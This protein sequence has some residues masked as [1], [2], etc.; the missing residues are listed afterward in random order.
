MQQRDVTRNKS[1]FT[2]VQQGLQR[3]TLMNFVCYKMTN[4]A[5]TYASK[6]QECLFYTAL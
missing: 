4:T 6:R 3:L 2:N 1:S 5:S